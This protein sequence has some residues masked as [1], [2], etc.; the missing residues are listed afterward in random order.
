MAGPSALGKGADRSSIVCIGDSLT[1]WGGCKVKP[2]QLP[3]NYMP[4]VLRGYS[5]LVQKG[6]PVYLAERVGSKH[7]VYNLS[8]AGG[9]TD[10]ILSWLS[11]ESVVAASNLVF[12]AGQSTVVFGKGA[13]PTK[14]ARHRCH[15]RDGGE[16]PD[17]MVSDRIAE[18][19]GGDAAS[20][21]NMMPGEFRGF[22]RFLVGEHSVK[23]LGDGSK[24]V[25]VPAGTPFTPDSSR[26][27]GK[28]I[29]VI[30]TGTNDQANRLK[31][32]A[33]AVKDY[34]DTLPDA[35]YVV[36]TSHY[37]P[38]LSRH[39]EP[40]YR[41]LFGDHY[42]ALLDEFKT[43]GVK[44]AIKLGLAAPSRADDEWISV[45]TL[46]R[47]NPHFNDTGCK[48][49]A[50][51]V[52]EKLKALGYL[53]GPET[54][55]AQDSDF[56]T[57]WTFVRD[58]GLPETVDL[59]H[60]GAIAHDFDLKKWD[61][62]CGGLP[63]FGHGEYRKSF[64]VTAEDL[65]GSL[66]LEFDGVM[67]HAAVFVNGEKA[68][69]RANG[70]ASFVVPLDGRVRE[71]ANEVRVTVDPPKD[72]SRWYPG[73]GIYRDVR[74]VRAPRDHVV[75]GSVAVSVARLTDDEAELK[76]DY[77]MSVGGRKSE[78]RRIG[79]PVLWSPENPHLYALAVGDLTVR[80]GI[81]TLRF[82]PKDGFFLNGVR[83]QMKGVCL[84]HDLGV[85]GAAFVKEAARRLLRLLKDMGCD[86]IRTS[87]NFPAPALLDLC[88]EMGLMVMDEA[89]DEWKRPKVG[90]GTAA[91]WEE[92]HVRDLVEFVRRDRNHPCVVMWSAGNELPEDEPSLGLT[93]SGVSI[94]RELTAIF[95][96]NDPEGRPVTAG[97]WKDCT[98][99]NGIGAA[100]DVFGANYLPKFYASYRGRQGVIGTETCSTV[101]TR[102]T[103]FF[104]EDERGKTSVTN[105]VSDY[106]LVP[107][108][109]N[110]YPPDVE[111][112]AQEANPHVYGEFVWT[113]FD[114]LGEPD[115][116]R[117]TSRSS[118]F[119]IFDLCGFPK[120]RY[121]LYRSQWRP[122]VPTA[123]IVP[124]W[125]WRNGLRIPVHVFTSGDEAELFVN[126]K[127]QGRRRKG[128]GTY[129]LI[130]QDVPY[131]A[132]VLSVRTWKAGRPWAEDRRVTAGP[133][134]R[135]VFT[136]EICGDYLLRS[137][138]AVDAQGNPVPDAERDVPYETPSG[139]D[140]F[141]W[142]NGD[143]GDLRSLRSAKASSFSGRA[144]LV[145]RVK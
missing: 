61:S 99:T 30:F 65:A 75:P 33:D 1:S 3:P 100:T 63:Y 125:N 18:D 143:P 72:S 84:H 118:Y 13:M 144:L 127:S 121:W 73:F 37:A 28:S 138:L 107:M 93:E 140:Y 128:T 145:F 9:V 77:E 104:P 45:L 111:F 85:F 54:T 69:E 10:S 15:N 23:R 34:V 81:R 91:R 126:G 132:G 2:A 66:R 142:C 46:G 135:F 122:D 5:G 19:L 6:Y 7:A 8:R 97:H 26:L 55:G 76:I 16:F 42:I 48:V 102:G 94:A 71:G 47:T 98:T 53:S 80:Y 27:F 123:H 137:V 139:Y 96:A 113:G 89:F 141:G 108:H 20:A 4:D 112:A 117:K 44:R 131:E 88:D 24:P 38:N 49:L 101:S 70:Y 12:S 21:G 41:Q 52:H 106:G 83:R 32:V 87:H 124:H 105:R 120:S 22:G 17:I 82:D 114:Y 103:F 86:A 115:P 25:T 90:N 68:A 58:G 134:S 36:I 74:L 60:D 14:V 79:R 130:W 95:H 136:D 35:R 31:D 39:P 109:G 129:R 50:D 119:G 67:S 78:T 92:D 51:I 43:N 11:P 56:M 64:V 59:P 29:H 133:F 62:G 116:W 40:Y 57:G 110:D